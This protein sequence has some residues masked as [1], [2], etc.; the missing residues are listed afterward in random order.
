MSTAI[1][2]FVELHDAD[3]DQCI[4]F[5]TAMFDCGWAKHPKGGAVFHTTV[6]R[7]IS[8]SEMIRIVQRDVNIAVKEADILLW[9][10]VCVFSDPV[11]ADS[12]NELT[13][14]RQDH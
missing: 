10:G 2:V 8:D 13:G 4:D 11:L 6:A 5:D 12:A 1:L 9:D 14:D 3:V 7:S